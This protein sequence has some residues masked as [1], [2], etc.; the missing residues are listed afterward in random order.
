MKIINNLFVRIPKHKEIFIIHN[1]SDDLECINIDGKIVLPESF[2]Y[3]SDEEAYVELKT[4]QALLSLALEYDLIEDDD[5]D[6]M[7]FINYD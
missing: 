4:N 5:F 2:E 1:D 3:L 7:E 6:I